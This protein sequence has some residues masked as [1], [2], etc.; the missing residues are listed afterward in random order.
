[1]K[2]RTGFP[3]RVMMGVAVI[4]NMVSAAWAQVN[5]LTR[6]YDNQRTGANLSESILN[7]SNVNPAQFGK[8]FMLPV[9]DQVFAGILYVSNLS[10]AGGMHNVI[11]VAT[12]N[13]TVYAFDADTFGPPLWQQN[14]NG[15]G[16]PTHTS[17]VGQASAPHTAFLGNENFPNLPTT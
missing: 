3:L 11:F 14:F 9:D 15:T 17:E 7:S 13:N 8:L 10:I 4:L 12:V 1:M 2:T 5:V 6:N 16:R